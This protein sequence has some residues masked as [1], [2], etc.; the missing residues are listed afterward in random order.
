[1]LNRIKMFGAMGTT[2]DESILR[3]AERIAK[4]RIG[5]CSELRA[6]MTKNQVYCKQSLA[7]GKKMSKTLNDN[8]SSVEASV[9]DT[10]EGKNNLLTFRRNT[11][12]QEKLEAHKPN[13]SKAI[14]EWLDEADGVDPDLDSD[15]PDTFAL[16]K[17]LTDYLTKGADAVAGGAPSTA[18]ITYHRRCRRRRRWRTRRAT[19][20][21]PAGRTCGG[22]RR[23]RRP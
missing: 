6:R 17:L 10:E 23:T 22:R 18:I 21:S 13:W 8:F 15:N 3:R 12:A 14:R 20:G 16:A 7:D 4:D 2:Q 19:A 11:E 1:M 5:A 9:S